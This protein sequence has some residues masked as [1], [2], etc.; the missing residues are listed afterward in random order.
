MTEAAV[1]LLS[2]MALLDVV[3]ALSSS[4]TFVLAAKLLRPPVFVKS[5]H[6]ASWKIR[7]FGLTPMIDTA[8]YF[9]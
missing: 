3:A 1:H 9:R 6:W 8:D 5:N 7:T 4:L 2:T